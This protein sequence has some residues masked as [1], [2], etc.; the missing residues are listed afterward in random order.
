MTSEHD[1]P[2]SAPD[3]NKRRWEA[4]LSDEH[5]D[6]GHNTQKSC[7]WTN[8]R[9]ARWML[10]RTLLCN[11]VIH[12]GTKAYYPYENAILAAVARQHIS[13]IHLLQLPGRLCSQCKQTTSGFERNQDHLFYWKHLAF[14]P[15]TD[16][17]D[18]ISCCENTP[19]NDWR[20]CSETRGSS[21]F[22]VGSFG[23]MLT[24]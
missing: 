11:T 19:K 3:I 17:T 20:H 15:P 16:P 1:C 10:C 18:S 13:F 14:T 24:Q 21:L 5:N 7:E 2:R 23:H 8:E 9:E 22:C 6:V 4:S 12:K